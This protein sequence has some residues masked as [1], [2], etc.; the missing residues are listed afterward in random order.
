[1]MRRRTILT[2]LLTGLAALPLLAA[3]A[4]AQT[5]QL[6][7]YE[8]EL[9]E[10][11]KKEGELTWYVAHYSAEHAEA[12]AREFNVKF[13]DVKVNV[14]RSTA[15][16]AYQRLSQDMR[17]GVAQCDVF[18]STDVGHYTVLKDEQALM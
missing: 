13:P 14:V 2:G 18:S 16:V 6:T 7:D 4:A 12:A 1:M 3:P 11:A 8:K 10:A 9:Y 15:Q 17:A 5:A